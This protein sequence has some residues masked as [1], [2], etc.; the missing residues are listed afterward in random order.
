MSSAHASNRYVSSSPS[1]SSA[2]TYCL[3]GIAAVARRHAPR[4]TL[5]RGDVLDSPFAN[6]SFDVVFSS[7]VAEHFP[8]GPGALLREA[9]RV[10]APGGLLLLIVPYAS[11]FRRLVTHRVYGAYY[12]WMRWRGRPLA[13]TEHRFSRAEV[14]GALRDAGFAVETTAPDDFHLP[15]GKGLSLDLGPLVRPAGAGVGSWELNGFG[16]ALA[17]LL[18]TFSPWSAC[19]GILCVARALE[20]GAPRR[21]HASGDGGAAPEVSDGR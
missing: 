3:N 21:L 6:A 12:A 17:R 10:L 20:G 18:G 16:R 11:P 4:L 5:V 13:F 15:W 9:R 1:A 7:Y 8:E 2:R 14:E 19:A